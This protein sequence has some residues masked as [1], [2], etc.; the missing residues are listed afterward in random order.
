MAAAA[1]LGA[2]GTARAHGSPTTPISR[3]AAC[4]DGGAETGSAACRAA[5]KANSGSGNF[6]NLRIADVG[7]RDRQV[8]VFNRAAARM[9]GVDPASALGKQL[10]DA[11]PLEGIDG[12]AW[13]PCANPY[14]SLRIT[15]GHPERNRSP[16]REKRL[17]C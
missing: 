4:A 8:V 5:R 14:S 13:W 10:E 16:H 11:L 15:S 3:T 1:L 9:T 17:L 2:P 7:G 6:D 12:R